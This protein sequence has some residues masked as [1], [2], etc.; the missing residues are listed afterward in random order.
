MAEFAEMLEDE[1]CRR[2]LSM[3]FVA[4]CYTGDDSSVAD[5]SQSDMPDAEVVVGC[6][7]SKG[8]DLDVANSKG[9]GIAGVD[10]CMGS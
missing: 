3:L 4:A 6:V 8:H 10:E 5:S 1:T 7:G 9:N 2:R